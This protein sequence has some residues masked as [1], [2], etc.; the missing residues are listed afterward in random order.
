MPVFRAGSIHQPQRAPR[1]TTASLVDTREPVRQCLARRRRRGWSGV[2]VPLSTLERFGARG[3]AGR[4]HAR[5]PRIPG[6]VVRRV[7]QRPARRLPRPRPRRARRSGPAARN[8][9]GHAAPAVLG[10]HDA[11]HQRRH[12]PDGRAP[13]QAGQVD[14]RGQY[15]RVFRALLPGSAMVTVNARPWSWLG[16]WLLHV[17]VFYKQ[18]CF[19]AS[20]AG[21]GTF[22]MSLGSD[23]G[24]LAAH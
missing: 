2:V 14:L 13:R 5:E 20:L 15:R 6:T 11:R 8:P 16:P 3:L 17:G 18:M 12:D 1:S 21:F 4:A 10:R 7:D 22:D 9:Q 23:R 24:Q 19:H